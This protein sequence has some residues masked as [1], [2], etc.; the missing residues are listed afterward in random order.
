MVVKRL[1][2]FYRAT[3]AAGVTEPTARGRRA[4]RAQRCWES[5]LASQRTPTANC[6]RL[7]QPGPTGSLRA[8]RGTPPLVQRAAA[9][10]HLTDD[11]SSD[12]R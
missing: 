11:A 1:A 9:S 4:H 7:F 2:L 12:D 5:S 3:T 6:F 10:K 8:R